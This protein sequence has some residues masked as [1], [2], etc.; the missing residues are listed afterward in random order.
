[1]RDGA[2]AFTMNNISF[3]TDQKTLHCTL[4]SMPRYEHNLH[5]VKGENGNKKY[6]D[7]RLS[8]EDE[9]GVLNEVHVYSYSNGQSKV[10]PYSFQ[11]EQVQKMEVI[12]KDK[13]KT[14]RSH[15]LGAALGI[16]G[17]VVGVGAIIIAIAA[18]SVHIGL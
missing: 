11:L 10:G 7:K 2:N 3:S 5:M 16:A 1:M 14:K 18:S 17:G 9:S 6:Q 13:E 15:A 8:D 12:E 4:D